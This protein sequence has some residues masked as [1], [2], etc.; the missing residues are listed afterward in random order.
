MYSDYELTTHIC[1]YWY[2]VE[3]HSADLRMFLCT[4]IKTLSDAI[5]MC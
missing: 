3:E 1:Q 2:C 4:G 5:I